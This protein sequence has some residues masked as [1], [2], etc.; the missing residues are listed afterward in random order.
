MGGTSAMMASRVLR[1]TCGAMIVGALAIAGMWDARAEGAVGAKDIGPQSAACD[2]HDKATAAWTACVGAARSDIP[3]AELFYAGYWLAKSGRYSEALS[4][5]NRARN[6]DARILTYIGFATRKLGRV[7]EALPLYAAALEKDPGY[8]VAR[9]Y[10][11]EAYL[12]RG[13]PALARA[14]LEAIGQQ[15]GTTC[16]AYIDL[17]HH[18]AEFEAQRGS[19]G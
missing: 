17:Q 5:L 14:Q 7:D 6:K 18:V 10:L 15:C 2:A 4:Y 11:G 1:A 19:R 13:E 8:V 3:D 16:A 12:M 9:A